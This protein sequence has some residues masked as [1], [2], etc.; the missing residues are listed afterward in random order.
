AIIQ[1]ARYEEERRAGRSA[2]EA[3]VRAVSQPIRATAVAAGAASIS[4]ASLMLT[5]FRGFSQFGFIGG[6]GMVLSWLATVTVLPAV[7]Y[8]LDRRRPVRPNARPMPGFRIAQPLA[9]FTVRHPR[10]LLLGGGL[11]TVLAIALVPHYV[12]DP[13]EYDFRHLRAR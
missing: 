3:G 4:Y 11:V 5:R 1:L 8:L 10:W 6:V 12:R 13:F 2:A 9:R 7:L